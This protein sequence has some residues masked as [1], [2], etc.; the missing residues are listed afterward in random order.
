MKNGKTIKLILM[1]LICITIILIGIF[2]VYVKSTNSYQNKLPQYVLASD[3]KGATALEFEVNHSTE[4]IY[5]DQDGNKVDS[6][7]VTEENEKDYKKEE[8][9]INEE[10]ALTTENYEKVLKIMKKRLQF[11]KTDQYRLDLDKKTGKIVLTFEDDYPQDIKSLLPMQGKLELIDS[12]TNDVILDNTHFSSAHTSYAS[13]NK[14]YE[15]YIQLE[16]NATGMEKIKEIDKYKVTQTD[17]EVEKSDEETEENTEITENK[18][19][20]LFDGESIVEVNYD[21][22]LLVGKTLRVTTATDLTTNSS[23]Q[24]EMN[25]NTVITKLATFGKMPVVYSLT[26]EEYIQSSVTSNI[27][28]IIV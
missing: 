28:Y 17:T 24:S 9:L 21:D 15:T 14:G 10:T 27:T 26:A 25:T 23:I 8:K 20:V 7:T 19:K 18:L 16:L 22:I 5:Y 3:I 2:G 6:S 4:T 11:L 12:N 13:V 1:I